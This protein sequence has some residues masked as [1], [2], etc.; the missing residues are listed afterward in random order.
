MSSLTEKDKVNILNLFYRTELRKNELVIDN[1]DCKIAEELNLKTQNV[2][3]FL[4]NH[5]R[6]KISEYKNKHKC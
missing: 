4:C 3:V 5:S 6:I 1:R 2:A